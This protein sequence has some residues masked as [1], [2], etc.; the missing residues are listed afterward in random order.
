MKRSTFVASGASAARS[1]QIS[2]A[3][4]GERKLP[5]SIMLAT[6]DFVPEH[7]E[8]CA[9]QLLPISVNAK[10]IFT[11]GVSFRR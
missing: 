10:P 6:Y 8:K 1:Q 7:F 2:P 3:E 4:E 5:G 11:P 9:G